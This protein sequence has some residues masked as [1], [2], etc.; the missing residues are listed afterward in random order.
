MQQIASISISNETVL[1]R[2]WNGHL[3]IFSR[4]Q[5][6]ENS[7]QYLLYSLISYFEENSRWVPLADFVIRFT[8]KTEAACRWHGYHMTNKF[9]RI[10]KQFGNLAGQIKERKCNWNLRETFPVFW[11]RVLGTSNSFIELLELQWLSVANWGKTGKLLKSR[12]FSFRLN[13]LKTYFHYLLSVDQKA[14]N[15][16]ANC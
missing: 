16:G 2:S 5:E 1:K 3:E 7:R 4:R 6:M 8:L 13:L 9:L 12:K 11:P 15:F 14:Q 10:A